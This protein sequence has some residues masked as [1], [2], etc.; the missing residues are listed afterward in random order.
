M[1]N[2]QNGKDLLKNPRM[3]QST[4]TVTTWLGNST[5]MPV[6]THRIM[7]NGGLVDTLNRGASVVVTTEYDQGMIVLILFILVCNFLV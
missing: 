5:T 1:L 6:H 3:N 7:I 4:I 2:L